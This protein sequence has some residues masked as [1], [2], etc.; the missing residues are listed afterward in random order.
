MRVACNRYWLWGSFGMMQ[1]LVSVAAILQYAEYEQEGGFSATWDALISAGEILSLV[2]IWLIFFPP[3][4]YRRWLQSAAAGKV[5][6][7]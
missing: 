5:E 6:E 4:F 7:G 3:V 2:L 1:V